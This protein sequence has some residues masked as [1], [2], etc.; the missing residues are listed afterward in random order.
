MIIRVKQPENGPFPRP[1]V[2]SSE[3]TNAFTILEVIIACAIFF[4]VSF[5]V[6]EMVIQGLSAARSLQQREPDAGMLAATLSLTNRLEEGTESGDFED[7]A[8]GLYRGYRWE[9]Y[10]EEVGSNSLFKVD[11][12]VYYN[13]SQGKRKGLSE[14]HM[15]ILLYKP[16]SPPGSASGRGGGR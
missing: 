8:P 7:I 4:M 12:I 5:A 2:G 14:S 9:R 13:R 16:G 1:P 10:V 6:I 3:R 11:F 15:S